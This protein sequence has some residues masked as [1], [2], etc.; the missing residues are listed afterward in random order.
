MRLHERGGVDTR[1]ETRILKTMGTT[2]KPGTTLRN[3]FGE[4]VLVLGYSKRFALLLVT[5]EDAF[6]P[7]YDVVAVT[8]VTL[9]DYVPVVGES[10][11]PV[12]ED[13]ARAM[14]ALQRVAVGR[15]EMCLKETQCGRRAIAAEHAEIAS[16]AWAIWRKVSGAA[17]V[18]SAQHAA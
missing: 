18:T 17:T 2:H 6:L 15:D 10:L 16:A 14:C 9:A 5:N 8:T 1:G 7:R 13:R 11:R 3:R 4:R 12:G